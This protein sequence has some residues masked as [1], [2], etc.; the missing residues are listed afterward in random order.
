MVCV[1]GAPTD[2]AQAWAEVVLRFAAA[3]HLR[4][5]AY[6][7]AVWQRHAWA[8]SPQALAVE[9]ALALR[10]AG[11]PPPAPHHASRAARQAHALC[12]LGLHLLR[13]EKLPARLSTLGLPPAFLC[14]RGIAH[15]LG[16]VPTVAIIGS[17]RASGGPLQWAFDLAGQLARRGVLVISGGAFGIDSAAHEGALAAGGTTVAVVGTAIDCLYPRGNAP[18]YRRM[19]AAGGAILSE[20]APLTP[21]YPSSH[22]ARNRLIA[23]LADAVVVAEAGLRS[24]TAGAVGHAL[25]LGRPVWVSPTEVGG[26][27][28]GIAH[29]LTEGRATELSPCMDL[30]LDEGWR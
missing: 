15:H 1:D 8:S 25:R 20:H 6:A 22:A 3:G 14:S 13:P 27:R 26:E 11:L 2:V 24:G 19:L 5:T 7:R 9:L 28:G 30:P 29:W 10:A 17:R 4:R 18:L 23:C 12:S 21:T 16:A